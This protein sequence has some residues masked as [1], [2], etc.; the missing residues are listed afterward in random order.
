MPG[1]NKKIEKL[2]I[3]KPF[4]FFLDVSG[5]KIS[6]RLDT[7]KQVPGM[8]SFSMSRVRQAN[9]MELPTS[10]HLVSHNAMELRELLF[11]QD[12]S[13]FLILDDTSFSGNTNLIVADLMNQTFPERKLTITHG[14]LLMNVGSL[15]QNPGARERL[16]NAGDRVI[17]GGEMQTPRD[18]G[19]HIFDLVK[20]DDL[21]NHLH[22]V[23]QL[24]DLLTEP[25]FFELAAAMLADESVLKIVF[26][27]VI[28][29]QELE[30]KRETGHF[31]SQVKLNGGFHTRNP[32]LLPAVIQQ[33]H[34]DHP[35][36]WR[37]PQEE[38]FELLISMSKMLK[39]SE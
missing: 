5:G 16:V 21:A 38:V 34:V 17:S 9:R 2:A 1:L 30:E 13:N 15:G 6:S 8:T 27:Q 19:W 18:D 32:Q 36:K 10:G 23:L 20:Q 37:L 3:E 35:G 12:L 14:L 24:I 33:G 4:S 39:G 7:L 22:V 11:D 29:S 26:P 25:N 28:T 31:V